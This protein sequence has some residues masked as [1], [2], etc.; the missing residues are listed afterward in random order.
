[1]A[2]LSRLAARAAHAKADVKQQL[3][4]F[5]LQGEWFALPI[6][7]AQKVIPM[8]AVYGSSQGF[9]TGLTHYLGHDIPVIDLMQKI[10]VNSSQSRLLL[11]DPP[12]A[13]ESNADP[14]SEKYLLI[15]QN[16]HNRELIGLP[17]DSQPT[18]RRVPQSAFAPIP[19]TY[20]QDG[21]I[22][23]ISALIKADKGH[24]PAFLLNLD[25]LFQPQTALP[26]SSQ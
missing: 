8:G 4:L 14:S 13:F 23:C 12:S 15:V 26:A 22:R 10:F 3:I 16:V 25:Q 21:K 2:T 5:C 11:G 18:L 20:L 17:I 19:P 1:M 9:G 6:V 7:A 24:P